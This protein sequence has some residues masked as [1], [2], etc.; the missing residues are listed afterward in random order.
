MHFYRVLNEEYFEGGGN[1]IF[2]LNSRRYSKVKGRV[3]GRK[4]T[5]TDIP[6]GG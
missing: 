4:K 3:G 6:W 5:I 2:L 1:Y